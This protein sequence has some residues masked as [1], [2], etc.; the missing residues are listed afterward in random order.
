MPSSVVHAGFAF[1]VAVGLLG[2]YYDRR[3]PIAVQGWQ[4]FLVLAGLFTVAAKHVQGLPPEA[5]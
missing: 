4:L 5:E 3:A 2:T 1:I